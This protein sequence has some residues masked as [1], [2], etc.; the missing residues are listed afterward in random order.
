MNQQIRNGS[1]MLMLKYCS[2][3]KGDS[4][5]LSKSYNHLQKINNSH[6]CSYRITIM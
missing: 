4:P 2:S 5:L 1:E 3:D 6:E